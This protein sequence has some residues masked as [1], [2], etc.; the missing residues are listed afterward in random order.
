MAY[1]F[2]DVSLTAYISRTQYMYIYIEQKERNQNLITIIN[3]S[4]MF[5][6][7]LNLSKSGGVIFLNTETFVHCSNIILSVLICNCL[8]PVC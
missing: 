8:V 2:I 3:L 6:L 5:L 1:R 7:K 4:Q